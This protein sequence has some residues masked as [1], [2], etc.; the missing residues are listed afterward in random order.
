MRIA[1][2]LEKNTADLA[3]L[4]EYRRRNEE[5]RKRAEEF[6]AVSRE[7]DNAKNQ[8][9]EL[10]NQR[11]VQFMQGFGIISNKLKE[12]YQV[13]SDPIF[14][15]WLCS[16]LIT[17]E[18]QSADDHSRWK[19]RTRTVRFGR[20]FLGGYLVLGHATEEELEEHLESLWRRENLVVSR[21]RLCSPCL[22]GT[23]IIPI[24][25]KVTSR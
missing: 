17:Y 11:L 18:M 12:M 9:T 20:S 14:W 13:R 4:Q 7:W 1:E 3:V 5:F 25:V 21:P 8:V 22:Q 23:N 2:R 24:H 16:I 15:L 19:C 6:E 10:R